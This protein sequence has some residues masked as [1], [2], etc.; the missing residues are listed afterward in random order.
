MSTIEPKGLLLAPSGPLFYIPLHVV[1]C[2]SAD[3]ILGLY[4][5]LVC[6]LCTVPVTLNYCTTIFPFYYHYFII[7]QAAI[8]SRIAIYNPCQPICK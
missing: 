8:Y 1:L 2:A 7:L 4:A 6:F 3:P 5:T